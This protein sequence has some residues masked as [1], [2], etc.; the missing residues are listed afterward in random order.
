MR[1]S[2]RTC[3]LLLV[4]V[5]VCGCGPEKKEKDLQL[6]VTNHVAKIKPIEKEAALA[7]WNAAIT[8]DANDY[9]L[10]SELTLQLRRIYSNPDEFAFLKAL[11]ASGDIR[12]PL[13]ARQLEV[14]YNEYLANQIEPELLEKIVALGTEIEKRFSTFRGAIDGEKVTDNEIKTILKEQTNRVVKKQA[15]EASKQVGQAVAADLIRL[16]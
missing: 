9:D 8:G 10:S 2:C 4:G 6:F 5:A 12:D 11:R 15:W 14:L 3:V 13:L 1:Q 16:V 7:S